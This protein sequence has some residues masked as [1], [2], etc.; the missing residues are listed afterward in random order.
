MKDKIEMHNVDLKE[1]VSV[2]ESCKGE[3]YLITDEGDKLNLKSRLCRVIGLIN[4]VEAGR[5]SDAKLICTD[6]DDE[7]KL[8]RFNLFGPV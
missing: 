4:L 2:V 1:F 5:L 3:V 7:S 6:P 8:F